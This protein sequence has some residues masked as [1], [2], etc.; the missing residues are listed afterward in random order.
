MSTVNTT[1]NHGIT[2]GNPGYLS[3]LTITNRGTI[4]NS[5]G[6]GIYGTTANGT[7]DNSGAITGT[8]SYK[9]GILLTNGGVVTNSGLIAGL[10]GSG[11]A[12]YGVWIKGAAGTVVNSGT[13]TGNGD[14]RGIY[15]QKKGDVTNQAAGYVKAGI[16]DYYGTVVNYGKVNDPF[17]EGIRAHFLTNYGTILGGNN[18]AYVTGQNI[19]T[20]GTL[21]NRGFVSAA[22]DG[23]YG[24]SLGSVP[25]VIINYG[26]AESGLEAGVGFGGGGTLIDAGTIIGSGGT[27]IS[28]YTSFGSFAG[29]VILE[30][31]YHIGGGVILGNPFAPSN[32]LGLSGV[33]GGLTVDYSGLQL[34]D[35]QVTQF[36]ASNL[37]GV[38]LRVTNTAQVPGTI[39]GFTAANEAIRLT[40]VSDAGN[41]ATY[42]FNS[43]THVLTVTGDNGSAT[44]HLGAA[45]YSAGFRLRRAGSG[46]EVLADGGALPAVTAALVDDT[47]ASSTDNITSD[48]MVSGTADPTAIITI[49]EGGTGLGSA[50]VNASGSWSFTPTGLAD[51]AHTLVATETDFDGTGSASVSIMLD[52]VRPLVTIGLVSD[53]G[54]SPSDKITSDPTI[55]GGGDP[56]AV[57]AFSDNGVVIGSATANGSG[58][59]TFSPS[60]LADGNHVLKASETDLAGNTG[61]ASL[62]IRLDTT[63]TAVTAELGSDTGASASDNITANPAISGGGAANAVVTIGEGV[64]VLGSATADASGGWT[65]S[66]AGLS[67]GAHTLV[68]SESD[69]AGNS[70][71]ASVTFTLDTTPPAVT[72]VASGGV[73][74]QAIQTVSGTIADSGGVAANALV[75]VFDN[76]AEVASAIASGGV[77]SASAPLSVGANQL[78]AEVTDLAGNTGSSTSVSFTYSAVFV[79]S[80][81][82]DLVVSSG[83]DDAPVVIL[84]GGR[85]DVL[86]GGTAGPTTISG[87]GM[88]V[89]FG[90]GV[91]SGGTLLSGGSLVLDGGVLSGALVW[92][93][94]GILEIGSG[95]TASGLAVS[96]GQILYLSGGTVSG[97]SAVGAIVD[98]AGTASGTVLGSDGDQ[99]VDSGATAVATL[100]ATGG[101]EFVESGGV[102]SGARISGGAEVVYGSAVAPVVSGNG[103]LY[104]EPGASVSGA[105]V[106]FGL[107]VI[108]GVASGGTDGGAGSDYELSGGTAIGTVVDGTID[109]GREFVEFGGT[110][111]GTILNSGEAAVYGSSIAAT[112]NSGATLYVEA[113]GAATGATVNSGTLVVAGSVSGATV[114]A[115]GDEFLLSGGAG[116][117]ATVSS[118]GVEF[119]QASATASGTTIAGGTQVVDGTALAASALSGG[120]QIVDSGGLA[121]GTT[122]TGADQ[123]VLGSAIGT[124]DASGSVDFVYAGGVASNGLVSGG[125]EIVEASGIAVGTVIVSGTQEVHGAATGTVLGASGEQV[126]SSGGTGVATVAGSGGYEYIASGG[127][128]GGA[129]VSGGTV[130]LAGGAIVIAGS[131]AFA[132]E[133]GG[134]LRL[135]ASRQFSGTVAGFGMSDTLDLSDIGFGSAT[136]AG[137]QEA[138]GNASGTLTVTSGVAAAKLTLLGQYVAGQFSL[139]PDGHGGTLVTDTALPPSLAVAAPI[140]IHDG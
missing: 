128:I 39:T 123:L 63:A 19:A 45:S 13:I 124:T 114:N 26:T 72:L 139:A 134:T 35:F 3:P 76:G 23:L 135:D 104:V 9:S 4:D 90:G 107:A 117:A 97:A 11:Q 81:G 99:F 56:N 109:G 28:M 71:L 44:L 52:T 1:I 10:G 22:G 130:E 62:T 79:V 38:V 8:G 67:D 138:P 46:T 93:S 18:G 64:L 126:V 48:P 70:G 80:S 88:E 21:I 98:D 30:A 69:I 92:S 120:L 86:S 110:A 53:T 75:A 94:G 37:N 89:V 87:G 43:S 121:S 125:A 105:D 60:A 33:L 115:G 58:D 96:G 140:N 27:A 112:V 91:E 17:G 51:G 6:N 111:I 108:G 29:V 54:T 129:T 61:S 41:D 15:L 55:S 47:G 25:E 77:W 106:A 113:G 50:T 103:A 40:T 16:L 122:L 49:S 68:A 42:H 127:T 137:F 36:D 24:N 131:L 83:Q 132:A 82:Q 119:V 74:H 5:S 102:A 73:T 136:A 84:S 14:E 65:F 100:A 59:W 101:V 57:V 85:V 116:A 133:G 78:T 2:L 20:P 66:P 118:G 7:V 12:G 34:R 32:T 95:A 31:G